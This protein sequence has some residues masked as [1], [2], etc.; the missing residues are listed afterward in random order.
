MCGMSTSDTLLDKHGGD[1]YLRF[2]IDFLPNISV[3]RYYIREG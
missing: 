3:V 2:V 1:G